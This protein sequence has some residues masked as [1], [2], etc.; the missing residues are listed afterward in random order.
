MRPF[1]WGS[2]SLGLNFLLDDPQATIAH[3]GRR[4]PHT[5]V[6]GRTAPLTLQ[7]RCCEVAIPTAGDL[8]VLACLQVSRCAPHGHPGPHPFRATDLL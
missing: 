8:Q 7:L 2:K 3:C 1:Q 4:V 6:R 5:Q